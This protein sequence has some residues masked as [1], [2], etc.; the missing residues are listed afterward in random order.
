MLLAAPTKRWFDS[1]P[2]KYFNLIYA[3]IISYIPTTEFG[4]IYNS[5]NLLRNIDKYISYRELHLLS[6]IS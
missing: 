2:T 1:Y 4:I 3:I 5:R 6:L